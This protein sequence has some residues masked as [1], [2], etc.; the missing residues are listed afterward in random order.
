MA[1]S[2]IWTKDDAIPQR[3]GSS[4][5]LEISMPGPHTIRVT[6]HE[7]NQPIPTVTCDYAGVGVVL[8]RAF[9]A[10]ASKG[11][12]VHQHLFRRPYTIGS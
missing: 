7:K 1:K 12:F 9:E 5:V 11:K 6:Y 8:F 2:F 3:V 4:W 10:A